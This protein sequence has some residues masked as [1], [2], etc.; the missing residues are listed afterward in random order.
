MKKMEMLKAGAS[1]IVTVGVG[2][3]VG[4]IVKGTTPAE[5]KQIMKIC[6][7]IGSFV[8]TC[9]AGDMAAKYTE[10]KIDETVKAVTDVFKGED[11]NEEAVKEEET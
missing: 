10:D 9:V 2:A 5:T 6:I 3:I 7:G 8:M 11:T 4:N 1:L